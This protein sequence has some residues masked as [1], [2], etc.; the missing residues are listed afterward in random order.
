MPQTDP[1]ALVLSRKVLRAL[2]VLNPLFGFLILV[3]LVASLVAE[4]WVMGALGVRPGLERAALIHGMRAIMVIGILAVPLTQVALN[5]LLAIVE[6]VSEG[7]PFVRLNA[8]RLQTIA[9]TVLILEV[10][11]FGVGI[12]AHRV[13]TATQPLDIDWNFSLTRWLAVLFLFVL[14]RVFE[15]GA[16][17][18]EDLEGTV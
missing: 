15:H 8:A 4:D 9:W 12:I 17:M 14:A 11:H 3:L 1:Y 6:T 13:S 18:R 16:Q 5:R 10:L 7:D 2:L